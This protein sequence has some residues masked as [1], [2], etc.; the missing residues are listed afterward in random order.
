[1]KQLHLISDVISFSYLKLGLYYGLLVDYCYVFLCNG[2]G[3]CYFQKVILLDTMDWSG[4]ETDD[5]ENP[6]VSHGQEAVDDV[7]YF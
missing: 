2:D 1:M 7:K 3:Q 6:P 5:H 4:Y